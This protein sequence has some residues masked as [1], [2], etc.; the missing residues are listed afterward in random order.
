MIK[1]PNIRKTFSQFRISNHKLEI[2]RWRYENI[3]SDQR[4]CKLCDS[5]EIEDEFHFAFKCP[6]FEHLRENSHNILKTMFKLNTT[7]ASKR[8]LLQHTMSSKDPVA[9]TLFCKFSSDCFN[10]RENGL[11]SSETNT[12]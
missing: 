11:K 2:E 10:E 4:I 3:S 6:R 9:L 12:P 1:N 8:M 7:D 5:H